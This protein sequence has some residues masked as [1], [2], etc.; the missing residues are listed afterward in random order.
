MNLAENRGTKLFSMSCLR[1]IDNMQYMHRPIQQ[2]VI[3]I[4][5]KLENMHAWLSSEAI[6]ESYNNCIDPMNGSVYTNY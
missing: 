3:S 6:I 2:V 4:E 5:F 1:T